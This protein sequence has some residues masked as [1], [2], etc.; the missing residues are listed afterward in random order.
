MTEP[1]LRVEKLTVGYGRVEAVREV[2]FEV[3]PGGLVTLVGANGAGK[4]SIINAVCGLVRP[5]SGTITFEGRPIK[6]RFRWSEI[7]PASARWEQAFSPDGGTTWETNWIMCFE[8]T[9][10]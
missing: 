8:R 5:R 2:S 1:I 9:G 3:A 10:D 4:S 7:T 6:V